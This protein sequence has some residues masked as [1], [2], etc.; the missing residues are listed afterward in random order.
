MGP[1]CCK[2]HSVLLKNKAEP[3][4]IEVNLSKIGLNQNQKIFLTTLNF[5]NLWIQQV[6]MF[7]HYRNTSLCFIIEGKHPRIE[8]GYFEIV[9]KTNQKLIRMIRPN[10]K[11]IPEP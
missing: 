9:D 2:Q 10:G 4:K 5:Y 3:F 8:A 6:L 1:R 11:M 7:I